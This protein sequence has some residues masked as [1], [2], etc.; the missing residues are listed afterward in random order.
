MLG[1]TYMYNGRRELG[2][3]LVRR[4]MDLIVCR[5]GRTWDMPNIIRG[6]S[7]EG[8]FG[9]D[10]YQNMMLWALPAAM[11]DSSLETPCHPGG[12]VYRIIAVA[13][14]ESPR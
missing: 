3:E 14:S 1:M 4:C 5:Q 9:S 7:G 10:Y 13:R 11:A 6:D 8:V 12:L 2:L